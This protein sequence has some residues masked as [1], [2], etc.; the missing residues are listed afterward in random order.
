MPIIS[1]APGHK[2]VNHHRGVEM[3]RLVTERQLKGAR[4]GNSGFLSTGQ[5]QQGRAQIRKRERVVRRRLNPPF[6]HTKP[7]RR[8]EVLRVLQHQSEAVVPDP[9]VRQVAIT[10]GFQIS[11]CLSDISILGELQANLSRSE[12]SA[13]RQWKVGTSLF[14]PGPKICRCRVC[15]R[16]PGCDVRQQEPLLSRAPNRWP[17]PF[18]GAPCCS[19]LVARSHRGRG[20][21]IPRRSP[22]A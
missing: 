14:R 6:C 5:Y 2:R 21:A 8:R 15:I 20:A 1:I 3:R 9:P 19:S 13:R 16:C 7:V 18:S 11:D 17:Y 22:H 4:E 10:K 12:L